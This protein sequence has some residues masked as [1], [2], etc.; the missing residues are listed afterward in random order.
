MRVVAVAALALTALFA[1]SAS[2]SAAIKFVPR[3]TTLTIPATTSAKAAARMPGLPQFTSSFT[4]EGQR[5]AYTMVGTDPHKN[6]RQTTVRTEILPLRLVF[7]DGTVLDGGS[8]VGNTVASP[9]FQKASFT[10]GHTQYGDAMRRA[11]FWTST[12]GTNYHVWLD[13]PRI[14]ATTTIHV[15]AKFGQVLTNS[16]G[17]K[18][19]LVRIGWFGSHAI[20]HVLH[21]KTSPPRVLPIFLT[22]DVLLYIGPNP[23]NC[24]VFG[25]HGA[26][27]NGVKTFAWAS[28]LSRG[29]FDPQ[30]GLSDVN[31]LSHEISEWYDDPFV[32]NVTP[33][34]F[35][36]TAPQYGCTNFLE[37]GD[38]LVGFAFHKRGY[39]L[40][41]EAFFSWFARERH[42][43]GINGQYTYL[44]NFSRPA[45]GCS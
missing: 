10:S 28:Y 3:S 18:I 33:E 2:A 16:G 9:I 24:C 34:W 25:F 7:S 23:N 43:Q 42:S 45:E 38:P 22:K 30:F 40:Q 41:D 32:N 35:T 21:D 39:S 27:T 5:Y 31:A 19:G 36:P 6:S 29:T 44:D 26:E 14:R 20:E 17:K 8:E 13:Q 4:F 15:P 12:R 37:V 11:E 1:V